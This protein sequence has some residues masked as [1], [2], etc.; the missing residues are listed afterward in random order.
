MMSTIFVSNSSGKNIQREEIL[1]NS[2][3]SIQMEIFVVFFLS[4]LMFKFF[5][6]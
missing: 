2:N 1:E 5:S 4:F 6:C 3:C